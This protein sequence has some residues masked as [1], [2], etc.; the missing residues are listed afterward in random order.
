MLDSVGDALALTAAKYPEKP[1]LIEVGGERFTYDRLN[2][3][4]NRLANAL[5]AMG[6][7][8]GDKIAYLFAN[9]HHFVECHFA[10]A[11]SGGVGVPLDV[12]LVGRELAYQIENSDAV[13]VI[14]SG[15][16]SDAV[17]QARIHL[18]KARVFICDGD[19]GRDA[20]DYEPIFDNKADHEPKADVTLYDDHLILF[21]AGP[22]GRPSGAVLRHKN[23]LFNGLSMVMDVGFRR[24]DIFQVIPPLFHPLSL[25]AIC[26]PAILTGATLV[27]HPRFEP[28]DALAAIQEERITIT[29]GPA[30]LLRM[31][32]EEPEFERFDTSSVRLMVNGAMTMPAEM[33][34]QVLSKFPSVCIA[35]TYGMTEASPCCTILPPDRALDKPASVGLPLSL[36]D[37]KIFGEDEKELPPGEIGEIVTRGNFMRGYYEDA[38]ATAG[39]IRNGWFYTGDLGKKDEEG[40][41]YLVDRKKDLISTGGE[42]VYSREVEEAIGLHPHV[43]EVAV[44]GVPDEKW[45]ETVAAVVAV[46]PGTALTGEDLAAHCR[47][48]LAD[49]KRP[50]IYKFV[51]FLPKSAAGEVLKRE[52]KKTFT[53]GPEQKAPGK[54]RSFD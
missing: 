52:I 39:A 43:F 50:R 3:R 51:E 1:A 40:F 23:S 33:R 22:G 9:T 46:A 4:V 29:W 21:T 42:N 49:Y 47:I 54:R 8:K 15:L 10:V 26:I 27:L 48:Q 12:R 24:D 6:F 19:S 7:Q 11:K 34:R 44:V 53:P 5:I 25:N 20:R 18:T 38:P 45:G 30:I 32:I 2:R 36:C 31:L 17:N 13:C 41:I 28:R 37:V 35:D 14:Y 16:F